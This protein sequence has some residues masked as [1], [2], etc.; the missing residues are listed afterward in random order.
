MKIQLNVTT[1]ELDK[2]M[3]ALVAR[4]YHE[5]VDLITNL[6]QQA[7]APPAEEVLKVL[8]PAD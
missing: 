8:P 5:V 6:V 2:V 1:D 4:P 3:A 7:N